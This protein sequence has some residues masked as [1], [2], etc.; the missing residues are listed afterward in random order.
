MRFFLVL[1]CCFLSFS[2]F[3]IKRSELKTGD[4]IFQNLDCGGMCDAIEAVT[5]GYKG[6]DFSHMGMIW[7]APN[8]TFYV[9]ESIGKG[10]QETE[11]D[12]F[13]K[14]S[15]HPH[16]IARVKKPYRDLIPEAI[17]FCQD[18]VGGAYDEAF[19]YNNGKYYCSELIY[20]AF[21]AANQGQ[22]VFQL[23]PMTYKDPVTHSYYP[24]WVSYFNT[25]HLEIPEG[26][27][28][29]NPGGLSTSERVKVLGDLELI[30]S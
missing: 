1:L 11:L 13:L 9:L 25:L 4:L 27:P 23:Y 24:V 30:G 18:H 29:C 3:S 5:E 6:R 12:E 28:G 2:A 15:T 14:R 16:L 17:K 21:K 7:R 19:L 10:V 20:D 26:Q 22:P 8:G